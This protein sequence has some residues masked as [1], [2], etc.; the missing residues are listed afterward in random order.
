MRRMVILAAT[1]SLLAALA[2]AVAATP[3]QSEYQIVNGR[4]A[5]DGRYP[6]MA[7]MFPG[8][9]LCGSSVVAEGWL[10]TAAHCMF[11]ERGQEIPASL[12]GFLTDTVDI[13]AGGRAL[14][15]AQVF[16]HPSY[17]PFTSNNDI[18]LVR[19][20]EPTNVTPVSLATTV[21]DHLNRP[22]TVGLVMGYGVIR[23]DGPSSDRL[24]EVDVNVQ[25]FGPC[26]ADYEAASGLPLNPDTMICVGNPT[27]DPGNPG[28]DSCQ[29]DSGG[30]LISTIDGRDVQFG[31]VSF[32]GE[33]GVD[34]PGVYTKV[35]NYTDWING[36][37][38]G[39]A[40]P[41][42]P[43]PPPTDDVLRLAAGTGDDPVANAIAFSQ[44]IF[45]REASFGVLALSSNFPDALGGSALASYLGPLL[46]VNAQGQLDQETLVE[47]QR[48][49][50]PGSTVYIL[51]GVAVI[52]PEVGQA[53]INAG[54][55][56]LRLGGPGRQETAKLVA[57]EVN[58]VVN[59]VAGPPFD[60]VI[61]SFEG[62]WPD[63]VTVG[64]ISAFWGIPIL[65]TPVDSLGG[66]ASEYL[67]QNRPA[68]VFVTGGEAVVSS[69][70]VAQIEAITGPESVIRLGGQTR[71]ET[72]ALITFLNVFGL[73]PFHEEVFGFPV[74][75][76][77]IFAVNLRRDDAFAHVLAA[78]TLAGN[79]AGVFAPVESH[80]GTVL[81]QEVLDSVCGFGAR[82]VIIGGP[83]LVP[84]S[85]GD[86]LAA[87]SAGQG[88][89]A[90]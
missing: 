11:D 18:A 77:V 81:T 2:P 31:V 73:Y 16:V 79:F 14:T 88:C 51:G 27:P 43:P 21:E 47:F 38:S 50:P 26:S 7:A 70:V 15:A 76:E 29:G 45:Q 33:C 20:N 84:D 6:W 85:V 12:V 35:S 41:P 90:G 59:Q 22:P 57:D 1:L 24:L 68:N 10:L 54:F 60:S 86:Q 74:A 48:V 4:P 89:A 66:P 67:Q 49:L 32:G 82:V 62:N 39:T 69:N 72:S 75:P 17:D 71:L 25:D 8:D 87:A 19:T 23:T 55:N 61:V 64:Q 42:P 63:A 36:V 44:V 34:L 13:S 58:R 28:N 46:Y 83:N 52:G 53:L 65:L 80:D 78:S 9:S 3:S 37:I 56:P 5:P 30:P 40:P